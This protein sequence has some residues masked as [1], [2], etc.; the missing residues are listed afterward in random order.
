MLKLLKYLKGYKVAAVLAPLFKIIEA[1]IE[2]IIPMLVAYMIDEGLNGEGNIGAVVWIG[3]LLIVLGAV[4]LG[5]SLSCQYLASKAAVGFGCNIR[6]ALYAHVQRLAPGDIDRMGTGTLVNRLSTDVAQAQQGFAMFLRLMLRAPFIAVG[7]VVMSVIVAPGLWYVGVS[8]TAL[9]MVVLIVIMSVSVPRFTKVQKQLDN[10]S[11]ITNETVRGERVIRAFANEKSSNEKFA[12]AADSHKKASTGA[13]FV[14]CLLNPL[15][16]VIINLA[17]VLLVWVGSGKVINAGDPLTQGN[18]I[19]LVNY[20]MQILLALIAISTLLVLISKAMSSA[21]RINAVF[22]MPEVAEGAGA[23]PDMS[24]PLIEFRNAAFSFGGEENAVEGLNFKLYRGEVLGIIGTTG[25]GK[26]TLAGMITR[27]YRATEGEVFV[28]GRN[29][30]EYTDEELCGLVTYAP[31]KPLLFSGTVRSNLEFGGISD[32]GLMTDALRKTEAW[33]F[34]QK[35]DGL[36][37][38]VNQKG[39]NFSGGEK[40]RLSLARAV[41]KDA[42]VLILDDAASALDYVTESRVMKNVLRGAENKAVINIS[43]RTGAIRHADKILVLDGGKVVGFGTH[44]ELM[45]T[46]ELYGRMNNNG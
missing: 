22:D 23:V 24:A 35:K 9:T 39:S 20:M 28:A 36:D 30:L 34:V 10:V 1:I 17:V 40:Q 18:L 13:S 44:D 3:V 43:Q 11:Q 42:P 21:A 8:A 32:D 2:L 38:V 19:A 16:G 46:C 25:S 6:R 26:S 12:V 33:G 15:S 7:A 29:V 4:G 5:F 45:Q 14:S 27:F 37:T 31:Q 41:L